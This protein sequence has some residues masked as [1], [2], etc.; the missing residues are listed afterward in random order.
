[1]K[2]KNFYKI[3]A[4]MSIVVP[5]TAPKKKFDGTPNSFSSPPALFGGLCAVVFSRD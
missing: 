3:V 2:C 1:M 5:A 4:P